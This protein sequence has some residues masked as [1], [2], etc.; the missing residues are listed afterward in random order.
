MNNHRI[1]KFD[2]QGE[3]VVAWG[4]YDAYQNGKFRHPGGIAIAPDGSIFVSDSGNDRIQKFRPCTAGCQPPPTPCADGPKI[5]LHVQNVTTKN[6]CSAGAIVDCSGAV[7]E[8]D[9]ALPGAGPF[10][11]VY[12]L[13]NI[14]SAHDVAGLQC[15]ITYQ[16]G[17]PGA[18]DDGTG[19]DIFDWTL[20]ASLEFPPLD[21][22]AW[23]KPGSGNLMTWSRDQCQAGATAL[24]GYF[25]LGAYSLD[26]LQLVPRPVDGLAKLAN[27]SAVEIPL[28]A[29]DLGYAS[30]SQ[31][32]RLKGCNPGL[33]SDCLVQVPVLTTTWGGLKALYR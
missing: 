13:A 15:G 24:A 22:P 31:G 12:L 1:Q 3:F 11:N 28:S 25:Y 14:G 33:V 16:D 9:V 10:Y 5:L 6:A 20:C 18:L 32:A 8:G 4:G 7:T 26:R 27:C 29:G 30:F 2:S 21:E 23:P 19:I 17:T